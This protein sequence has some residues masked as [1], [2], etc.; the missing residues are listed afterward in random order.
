[1]TVKRS[2]IFFIS[3][4]RSY[5]FWSSLGPSIQGVKMSRPGVGEWKT[6]CEVDLSLSTR[7]NFKK[8][9]ATLPHP[10]YVY[11]VMPDKQRKI[12]S[13]PCPIQSVSV[14]TVKANFVREI[15]GRF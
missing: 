4:S 2:K 3:L 1:M 6:G 14:R 15:N 9:W 7:V 11:G 8:G 13:T 12:Y 5:E 10:T